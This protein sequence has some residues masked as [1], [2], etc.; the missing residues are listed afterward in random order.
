MKLSIGLGLQS[1]TIDV[2]HLENER[3]DLQFHLDV[4]G[5]K[6]RGSVPNEWGDQSS[7]WNLAG[8]ANDISL[9]RTSKALGFTDQLGGSLRACYFTFRSDPPDPLSLCASNWTRLIYLMW[10]KRA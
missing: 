6:I 9:A 5:G 10:F 1:L 2:S 8:T 4:F 3:S 7:I